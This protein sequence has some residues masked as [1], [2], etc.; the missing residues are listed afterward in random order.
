[1]DWG[2]G[3]RKEEE[4]KGLR[5]MVK[6]ALRGLDHLDG[7]GKSTQLLSGSNVLGEPSAASG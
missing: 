3:S 5:E 7:G 2:V 1:M 4:Q 6:R